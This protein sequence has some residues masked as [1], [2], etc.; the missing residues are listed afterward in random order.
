MTKTTAT[1]TISAERYFL[2]IENWSLVLVWNLG[3]VIWN[4]FVTSLYDAS[5]KVFSNARAPVRAVTTRA[6]KSVKKCDF[7][8]V[9]K[10]RKYHEIKELQKSDLSNLSKKITP[11]KNERN[12]KMTEKRIKTNQADA[13][14]QNFWPDLLPAYL[15]TPSKLSTQ[16]M[17]VRVSPPR[18]TSPIGLIRLIRPICSYISAKRSVVVEPYS[19]G[20]RA[21][22]IEA[23]SEGG[24]TGSTELRLRSNQ[25][26]Y[27]ATASPSRLRGFV[28]KSFSVFASLASWRLI[29]RHLQKFLLRAHL[30]LRLNAR[31]KVGKS[32]GFREP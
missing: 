10:L 3:F 31:K 9:A 23:Y 25:A 17:S 5:Y 6:R 18:P 32:G 27:K 22:S 30:R 13:L 19:E 26:R 24:G 2:K 12:G 4:F 20:G 7:L 21:G 16:S 29:S 11:P 14:L 28:V 1:P 15:S 8:R